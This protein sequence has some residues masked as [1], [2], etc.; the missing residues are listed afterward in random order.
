[1]LQVLGLICTIFKIPF[2][3][4]VSF[5][6]LEDLVN[7]RDSI[8]M[9]LPEQS[10][11]KHLQFF[12]HVATWNQESHPEFSGSTWP[13]EGKIANVCGDCS[14]QYPFHLQHATS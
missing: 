14:T 9:S 12:H 5:G 4:T 11:Y 10:R 3:D 13:R 7:L 8:L 1:M 2:A 6:S